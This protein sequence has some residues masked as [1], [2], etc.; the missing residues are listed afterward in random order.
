MSLR[1]ISKMGLPKLKSELHHYEKI[2]THLESEYAHVLMPGEYKTHNLA[3]VKQIIKDLNAH[4]AKKSGGTR[5]RRRNRK[6]R[7]HH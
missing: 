7:R 4:I 5:R 6:T 1:G 2:K 3:D